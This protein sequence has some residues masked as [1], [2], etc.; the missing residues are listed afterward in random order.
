[1]STLAGRQ[2]QSSTCKP[3]SKARKAL[4]GA[5]ADAYSGSGRML[6]LRAKPACQGAIAS[7]AA[8]PPAAANL[9]IV[10]AVAPEPDSP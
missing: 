7:A 8:K 5:V 1:L 9:N 2:R 4:V 6:G 3:A 10:R